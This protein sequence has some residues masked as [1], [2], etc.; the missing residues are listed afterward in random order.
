MASESGADELHD[1]TLLDLALHFGALEREHAC[2]P[3]QVSHKSVTASFRSSGRFQTRR[4]EAAACILQHVRLLRVVVNR[5]DDRIHRALFEHPFQRRS[6]AREVRQRTAGVLLD[7]RLGGKASHGRED[8]PDRPCRKRLFFLSPL[9]M[10]VPS[11]S[12]QTD[13]VFVSIKWRQGG[14]SRTV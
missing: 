7:N 6:G 5:R 2:Q 11:L 4:T 1:V 13:P 9:A 14:V 12:W 10:F 8:C 3:Q